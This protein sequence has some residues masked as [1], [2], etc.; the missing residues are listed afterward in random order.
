MLAEF[1]IVPKKKSVSYATYLRTMFKSNNVTAVP[2]YTSESQIPKLV[3]PWVSRVAHSRVL[4]RSEVLF[5][6]TPRGLG[7]EAPP[8]WHSR[9]GVQ[10]SNLYS[11]RC[12]D[13][14]N[15]GYQIALFAFLGFV[16][17]FTSL[18]FFFRRR[19]KK[20]YFLQLT[21][22]DLEFDAHVQQAYMMIYTALLYRLTAKLIWARTSTPMFGLPVGRGNFANIF[23]MVHL[24]SCS[25][26]PVNPRYMFSMNTLDKLA[27]SV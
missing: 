21:R 4:R 6:P 13:R 17:L 10:S 24:R 8:E 20:L 15:R 26:P 12:A 2:R 1:R 16:L 3:C 14:A 9:S 27:I 7:I 25:F 23:E 11:S 5:F 18:L 22:L 19:S